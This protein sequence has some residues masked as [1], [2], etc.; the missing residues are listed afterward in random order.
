MYAL[1]ED[2]HG[3]I[4]MSCSKGIFR[5]QKQQLN[6][7]ADGKIAAVSSAVYGLEHGLASSVGTIGHTPEG[8]RA[9]DGRLWFGM[10][11]GLSVVD[12]QRLS[13]NGLPP[14]VH[15]EDV[16]I[17]GR[18]FQSN[19]IAD[20]VP[21]RGDLA[22][23][24]SGVSF[25][26]SE[27]IRFKYKL[28]GHDPDWVDAGGRRAANYSNIAPG[29]YTFHVKAANSEGVWNEAGAHR[30]IRLA[31]H[32][33][34]TTW[35]SAVSML[36]VV[37]LIFGLHRQRV[38]SLRARERELALLVDERT[39]EVQR[40]R[41]FLR[42]VIDL[43]P[44]YIFAKERSG[45][46]TLANEA[47]ASALGTTVGEL[48]GRTDAEVN[49]QEKEVEQYRLDD[50]E[51]IDSRTAKFIPEEPFTDRHGN[52]HWLQVTKIPIVL[53]D[54]TVEQLLGVAT[55]ITLQKQAAIEM[56]RAKEAAEAA[57]QAKSA[58]LANMSHEIRTPMNGVLGMTDLVLATDLQPAQ[59]EYLEMAR[60]SADTLLTVV[61][62]VLDFSKIEAGEITFDPREFDLRESIGTTIKSLA[63]RARQKGL[64]LGFDVASDVPRCVVAD[65]HRVA[66]VLTN[67]LGNALKFT[68]H[69]DITL[70]VSLEGPASGPDAVL[71]FEVQDTGIGIPAEQHPHIFE[72]FKQADGSTTRKYGGT[73]LGLSI[74]SRLV[75][76]MGGRLS[77][78]S[79]EGRGSTFHFTV[80][81]GVVAAGQDCGVA[82]A[83][84]APLPSLRILL[85][86]DNRINQRV[87]VSLLERSGH[88]V[89]VVV[90][91]R[92]AVAA[93]AAT[94]FDVILMDVQMPE[95]NGL[96]ATAAIRARELTTGMRVPIV[97]M[98]AHAMRG[99]RERCLASGMDGYVAKPVSAKTLHQ[100]LADVMLA[101]RGT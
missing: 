32:F 62:D 50:L 42:T 92:A 60:S 28:E 17:D 51:V 79:A 71:R 88:V 83:D 22:F 18:T 84:V 90:D 35:F 37:G 97:A 81:V 34:Q 64:R 20:A 95:M 36:G 69:G 31:P 68:D 99:D 59:R 39:G 55:D 7:F 65:A 11:G 10:V 9:R 53:P 48:I 70:R 27:K 56:Q 89:T 78:D 33:Y 12:P 85:A 6:D 2:N 40:Q 67:L 87:A 47:L 94:A 80:R 73:G 14:P 44:S 63:V 91:G 77:V 8:Y 52:L 16:T 101:V 93:A 30:V 13:R 25:L 46:F 4:W 15:I 23:R 58:F 76:A 26:A 38:R 41:T 45:R 72:A 21:G 19:Q 75:E 3:Y 43:N 86:E 24:Y 66:Q 100:A 61:N 29:R 49:N 82:Q 96:D 57:T 98:T 1:I 74:S 54:G 5:V